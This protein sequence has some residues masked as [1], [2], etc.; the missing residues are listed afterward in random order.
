MIYT[1]NPQYLSTMCTKWKKVF[2][3]VAR[4]VVY[5][6]LEIYAENQAD[7]FQKV[8]TCWF[9]FH[10]IFTIYAQLRHHT[11]FSPTKFLLRFFKALINL[12]KRDS[13]I[14]LIERK[15]YFLMRLTCKK[16]SKLRSTFLFEG[17]TFV[18]RVQD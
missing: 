5:M 18:T 13:R 8:S 12:D 4:F 3:G 14:L 11:Q 10:Q 2:F 15:K 6:S 7:E 16:P 9:Y 17:Q 1:M